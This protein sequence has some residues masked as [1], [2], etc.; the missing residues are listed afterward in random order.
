[1]DPL[2]KASERPSDLEPWLLGW[3]LGGWFGI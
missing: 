1:M 2:G 3:E